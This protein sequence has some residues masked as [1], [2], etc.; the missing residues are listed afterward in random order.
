[1]RPWPQVRVEGRLVVGVEAADFLR[2]QP[3]G[4]DDL[5]QARALVEHLEHACRYLAL[6]SSVV[7]A[8]RD[9]NARDLGRV[10]APDA[11]VIPPGM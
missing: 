9:A 3:D 10:I 8:A 7:N 5:A 11:G 6:R 1:L 4:H 2:D